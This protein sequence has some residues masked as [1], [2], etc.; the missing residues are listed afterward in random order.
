MKCPLFTIMDRRTQLGEE[1]DFSECL[2]E[3]C[4]WWEKVSQS[5]ALVAIY[6]EIRLLVGAAGLAADRLSPT[7]EK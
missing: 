6:Q 4:A 1:S 3:G 5:C 2:K 7:K